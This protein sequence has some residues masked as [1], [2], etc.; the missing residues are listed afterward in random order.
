NNDIACLFDLDG[1]LV[2]SE[3]IY[4]KIWEAIEKHWPTGIENFAYKIKGT[5]LEDILE[6]HFPE[7]AR[8]DITK[9]LLRLEGMMI[10]GPMPGAIEFIDALKAKGIPVALVTSSNG[11]KMDH[12]WHDMPGFKEKF[13]VIITGDEVTNSKPDPEG[14]LAAAKALGVDP[15]R[16]AVFEDS[17]Q[18][19][20]AGKAAGAFV[21]GIAGTLKASDIQPYSDIVVN[22]VADIYPDRLEE[23]LKAR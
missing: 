11:L 21:I 8:E 13:D 22:A 15:K 17:L 12:L 20:K 23:T 5:T 3:R 2:D 16:C 7:E 4:T 18:G 6:R 14:Y 19:V 9:E 10:Y 1:V